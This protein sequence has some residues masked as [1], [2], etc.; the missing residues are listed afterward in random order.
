MGPMTALL[1]ASLLLVAGTAALAGITVYFG[2]C[3][4]SF[5]SVIIFRVML[6]EAPWSLP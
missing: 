5:I 6:F 4:Y 3:D 2:Y 1:Y